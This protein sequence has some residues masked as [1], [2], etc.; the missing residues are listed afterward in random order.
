MAKTLTVRIPD[1]LAAWVDEAARTAGVSVG[2]FVRMQLEKAREAS[3]R[4]FLRLAGAVD[5]SVDLST[6]AGFS[7][8]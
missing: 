8:K 7:K 2:R 6:R 4:P 3:E 1:D 5:G